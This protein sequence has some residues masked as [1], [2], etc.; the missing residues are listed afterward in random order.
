MRV[1]S[2]MIG[3]SLNIW[4][5]LL[6]Y[7]WNRLKIDVAQFWSM[8]F[9]VGSQLMG[10]RRGRTDSGYLMGVWLHYNIVVLVELILEVSS[11][12]PYCHLRL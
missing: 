8:K 12:P 1:G 6:H 9:D 2:Y 7:Y 5:G 3:I 10:E 4:C 11:N